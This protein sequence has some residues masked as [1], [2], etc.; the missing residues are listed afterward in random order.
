MQKPCTLMSR[1]GAGAGGGDD[2]IRLRKVHF[3]F[4]HSSFGARAA[5]SH[6]LTRIEGSAAGRREL[7]H[8]RT[9]SLKAIARWRRHPTVAA[10][11]SRPRELVAAPAS[12]APRARGG[13]GESVSRIHGV[14]HLIYAREGTGGVRRRC[15]GAPPW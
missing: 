2:R 3:G 1:T 11:E 7:P 15:G 13:D 14:Q 4:R 6:A 12:R 9:L 10:E 8:A 5:P